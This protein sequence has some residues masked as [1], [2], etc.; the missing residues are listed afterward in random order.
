[1][2]ECGP[3]PIFAS[4][5]LASA[6]RRKKH[7]KTLVTVRE[8]SSQVKKNLSQSTVYIL[9]KHP[10]ITKP[11]KKNHN[12]H[13]H[14]CARTHTSFKTIMS[15]YTTSGSA[16]FTEKKKGLNTFCLDIAQKILNLELYLVCTLS[17]CRWIV[18]LPDNVG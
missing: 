11:F 16:C 17:H 13:T 5:T 15:M 18:A 9:P 14:T 3:C 12:A 7:G 10:H 8:T 6:L 1:M 2:E 4:F